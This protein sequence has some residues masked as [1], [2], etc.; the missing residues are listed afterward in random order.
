M[1]ARDAYRRD[2]GVVEALPLVGGVIQNI[3]D[4]MSN[5]RLAEVM[6]DAL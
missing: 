4:V 5:R 3:R 1:G 6:N 2:I